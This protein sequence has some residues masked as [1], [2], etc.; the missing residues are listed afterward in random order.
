MSNTSRRTS[1][2]NP[3]CGIRNL[4]AALVKPRKVFALPSAAQSK[5]QETIDRSF[6]IPT[7]YDESLSETRKKHLLLSIKVAGKQ[8]YTTTRPLLLTDCSNR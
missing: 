2:E 1:R 5:S 8:K 3:P 6:Q 4:V 7:A